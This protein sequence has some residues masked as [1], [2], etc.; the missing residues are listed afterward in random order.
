MSA[1]IVTKKDGTVTN[2]ANRL[3]KLTFFDFV[4]NTVMI[5]LIFITLYPVWYVLCISLSSTAAINSGAVTI[6]PK[7]T[8]LDAYFQILKTPRIPRAYWNSILYT[9]TATVCTVAMTTLYAYPLSRKNFV[10]RSPLLIMVII[11]MFFSGGM[12]PSFLLAKSLGLLDKIWGIVIPGLIVTFD[13]I[14]MKNFFEGIPNELY[15]AAVVDGASEFTILLKIFV[16]LAKP[17]I[18]SITLF[19][20]MGNW[21]SYLTPSIYFTTAEKMPLQVILKDMLMDMTAQNSNN[22]EESRFTPE[23]LKNATIFISVLP[24][25]VVYPFLQKYFVKGLTVGAIKG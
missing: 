22:M 19:I 10:F 21:N 6:W 20:A 25:L 3:D 16:P 8:N 5:L 4:N 15:E 14:V 1:K 11:T 9:F 7:E 18:A 17:A 12:I 13:L 2:K 23:A 24:F